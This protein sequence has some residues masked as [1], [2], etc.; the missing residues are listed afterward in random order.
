MPAQGNLALFKGVG[1]EGG[2]GVGGG[3]GGG[4]GG[5]EHYKESFPVAGRH[6]EI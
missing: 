1:A 4:R 2:S 5:L 6:L 3:A